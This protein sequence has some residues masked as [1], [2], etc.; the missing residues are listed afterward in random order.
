MS[1]SKI[2]VPKY[3]YYRDAEEITRTFIDYYQNIKRIIA[4]YKRYMEGQGWSMSRFMKD[5]ELQCFDLEARFNKYEVDMDKQSVLF[6]YAEDQ[7]EEDNKAE[8]GQSA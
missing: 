2:K 5:I 8:A 1:M 3:A 4:E 6:D 7:N